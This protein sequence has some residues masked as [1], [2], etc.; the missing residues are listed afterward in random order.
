MISDDLVKLATQWKDLLSPPAQ[1]P[2]VSQE[3]MEYRQTAAQRVLQRLKRHDDILP[4][5]KLPEIKSPV[6][7]VSDN[8]IF[9]KQGL[10]FSLRS[11]F[12]ALVECARKYHTK[13][14]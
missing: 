14:C 5:P 8:V 11:D 9:D 1:P 6:P 13:V 10:L 12:N 3:P 2:P 7:E 4:P